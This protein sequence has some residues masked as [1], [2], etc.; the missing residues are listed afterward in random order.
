PAM[1]A[2][3]GRAWRERWQRRCGRAT[4]PWWTGCD[5]C[6][7]SP[8]STSRSSRRA[9]PRRRRPCC[10]T[11]APSPPA[12]RGGR[13][14]RR[15]TWSTSAAG[16]VRSTCR[17]TPRHCSHDSTGSA[18]RGGRGTSALAAVLARLA[19]DAGRTTALVDGDPAG[20]GLD[21]LLGV[22]HDAGPRWSDL[23][24]ERG[25]FPPDRLMAALPAWHGVRVLSGDV[26]G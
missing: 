12:T 19:V 8:A 3:G 6:A 1:L 11:T 21:I 23:L 10:S 17:G 18:R 22:E 14:G 15:R 5:G 26:R 13:S 2:P 24:T 7:C 25:G 4:G 9:G 20:G 16:S